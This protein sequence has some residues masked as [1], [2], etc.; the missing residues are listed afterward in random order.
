MN[1]EI[2]MEIKDGCCGLKLTKGNI[3]GLPKIEPHNVGTELSP[4][5]VIEL[6]SVLGKW[7]YER[8]ANEA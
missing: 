3:N 5:D 1:K 8:R 6:I 4:D 2:L 7:L